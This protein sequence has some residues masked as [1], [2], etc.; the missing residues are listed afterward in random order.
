[1]TIS[2]SQGSNLQS[3]SF[4]R[5]ENGISVGTLPFS[6][7]GRVVVDTDR[8]SISLNPN[9]NSIFCMFNITFEV[10]MTA[11]SGQQSE[12]LKVTIDDEYILEMSFPTGSG[13]N[14]VSDINAIRQHFNLPP[15]LQ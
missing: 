2:V 12:T 8:R 1:M 15:Q 4:T 9:D 14:I 10:D 7:G 11:T 5:I 6:G 3:Y 13:K